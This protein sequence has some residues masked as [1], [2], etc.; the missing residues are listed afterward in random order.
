MEIISPSFSVSPP[1]CT[2]QEEVF[3]HQTT[4]SR[5][6][7]HKTPVFKVL[8]PFPGA[9]LGQHCLRSSA[10]PSQKRRVVPELGTT[11]TSEGLFTAKGDLAL[12]EM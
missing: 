1:F 12:S 4:L 11:S 5:C 10:P 2:F 6:N 3:L 7:S 9:G 8:L